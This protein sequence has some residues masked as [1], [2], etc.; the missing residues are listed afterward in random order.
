MF[1]VQEKSVEEINTELL[2]DVKAPCL[3]I[4]GSDGEVNIINLADAEYKEDLMTSLY[5]QRK[6]QSPFCG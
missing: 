6:S 1:I 3:Q 4:I 5:I 2:S